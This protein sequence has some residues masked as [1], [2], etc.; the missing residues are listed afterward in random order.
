MEY[1]ASYYAPSLLWPLILWCHVFPTKRRNYMRGRRCSRWTRTFFGLPTATEEKETVT[2]LLTQH[3][4]FLVQENKSRHSMWGE[5]NQS[6]WLSF[7]LC[8]CKP[9]CF[10]GLENRI[11]QPHGPGPACP[12]GFWTI[13]PCCHCHAVGSLTH[14]LLTSTSFFFLTPSEN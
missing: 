14:C 1:V 7:C 12:L 13:R 2:T 6:K 3:Y 5:T 11:M 10:L 4:Y 9:C 8:S